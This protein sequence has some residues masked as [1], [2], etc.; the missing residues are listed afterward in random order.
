MSLP[1]LEGDVR[2]GRAIL[3]SRDSWVMYSVQVS[4]YALLCCVCACVH[5]CGC[6]YM[7]NRIFQFQFASFLMGGWSDNCNKLLKS[8]QTRLVCTIAK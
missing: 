7:E 3:R 4:F 6:A 2:E 8:E 1:V 5:V